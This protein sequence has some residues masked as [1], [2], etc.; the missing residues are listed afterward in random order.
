MQNIIIIGLMVL[1]CITIN[2]L[3]LSKREI[4]KLRENLSEI[5]KRNTN[6][7]LKVSYPN[8]NLQGLI[9]EINNAIKIK[10]DI[11]FKYKEKDLEL[12]QSIANMS[13]DLRTPLTS[14]MGYMQL[15]EDDDTDEDDKKLYQI[16]MIYLEFKL[17]SIE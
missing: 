12:R 2:L 13:H 8:K 6:E 16:F 5:N 14:I 11:E 17:M 1:L 4:E 3:I 10:K 7:L 15:L 9:M